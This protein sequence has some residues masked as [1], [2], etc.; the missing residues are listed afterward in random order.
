M[1]NKIAVTLAAL[2]LAVMISLVWVAF[3][4]YGKAKDQ[5]G[6]ITTLTQQK[7]EAE[8]LSQSQAQTVG[9]FNTIAGATLNEQKANTATSQERQVIIK[10]VLKTEPCAVV[11]VPATAAGGLLDH[12]NAIRK[13]A[14]NADS[15]QSVKPVLD[16]TTS[17]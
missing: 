9:I 4:F 17:R 3:H 5:A 10:T 11:P 1:I 13:G 6:T 15:G 12:Y 7:N 16:I 8:F 14:G 2:V